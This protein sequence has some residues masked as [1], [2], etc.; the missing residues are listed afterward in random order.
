MN[1]R[2]L[3]L[4]L[5]AAVVV[6]SALILVGSTDKEPIAGQ[7]H[8]IDPGMSTTPPITSDPSVSRNS[9][10]N[11]ETVEPSAVSKP[12]SAT[13]ALPTTNTSPG[14]MPKRRP[15]A[16]IE[17][18]LTFGGQFDS[19]L[20]RTQLIG[21]YDSLLQELSDGMASSWQNADLADLYRAQIQEQL[22]SGEASPMIDHMVCGRRLCLAEF[23]TPEGGVLPTFPI[24]N[25]PFGAYQSVQFVGPDGRTITRWLFAPPNP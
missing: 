14:S 7:V 1:R 16:K 22:G 17:D 25:V 13:L 15:A 19:N 18:R 11:A 4:L 6:A 9:L 2:G 20:A 8:E 23:S 5:G 10:P 24:A 21:N 3:I 12:E